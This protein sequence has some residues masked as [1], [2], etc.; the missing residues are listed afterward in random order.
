MGRKHSIFVAAGSDS[1]QKVN[2][3]G[4]LYANVEIARST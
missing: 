2:C 3:L 1:F 4:S